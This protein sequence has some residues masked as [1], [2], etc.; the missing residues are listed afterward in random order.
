M[1]KKLLIIL[2]I[3]SN[4]CIADELVVP[5]TKGD[6]APYSGVLFPVSKA[7]E[8]EKTSI[9]RNNLKLIN[10]SYQRSHEIDAKT[11]ELLNKKI[12]IV[13]QQNNVLNDQVYKYRE[14]SNWNNLLWFSLGIFATGAAI[15][16]VSRVR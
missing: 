15:W 5:I 14:S 1:L 13:T 4:L 16:G 12:D 11:E 8:M 10:E 6:P 9:E 7:R 3:L 2:T